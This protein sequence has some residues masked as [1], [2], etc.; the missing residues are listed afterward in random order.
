VRLFA[1][2]RQIAGRD[3]VEL[4]LPDGATVAALREQLA[5]QVP[6][7]SATLSRMLIAI[8]AQYA[9]EKALVP[10]NSDVACIPPVSGG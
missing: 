8:N 7:I 4:D 3:S 6:Q 10:P 2:A 9:A 5:A 1:V